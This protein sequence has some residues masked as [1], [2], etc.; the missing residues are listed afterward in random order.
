MDLDSLAQLV[1]SVIW[2]GA[3]GYNKESQ[4]PTQSRVKKQSKANN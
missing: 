4:L 3:E 2:D 1:E